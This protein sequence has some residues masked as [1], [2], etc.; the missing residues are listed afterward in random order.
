MVGSGAGSPTTPA[1]TDAPQA[2][3]FYRQ[4][5]GRS[6][7]IGLLVIPLL[8]A[9]IGS[10]MVHRSESAASTLSSPSTSS[11]PRLNRFLA[12]LADA[13]FRAVDGAAYCGSPVGVRQTG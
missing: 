2:P 1:T 6:W 5:L 13:E 3:R 11:A 12:T 7:L 8:I 4:P 9:G 10:F